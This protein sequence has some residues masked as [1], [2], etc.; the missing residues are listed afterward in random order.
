MRKSSGGSNTCG[1]T[2]GKIP[3]AEEVRA[4]GRGLGEVPGNGARLLRA[5]GKAEAWRSSEATAAWGSAPA[6]RSRGWYW[7]V[8]VAAAGWEEGAEGRPGV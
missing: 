2:P 8:E 3:A 5:S 6:R 1:G 7:G 4:E